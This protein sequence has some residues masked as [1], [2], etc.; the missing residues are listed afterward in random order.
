MDEELK[1]K[2]LM[3]VKRQRFLYGRKSDLDD[4]SLGNSFGLNSGEDDVAGVGDDDSAGATT[5]GGVYDLS[6]I[7]RV[8]NNALNG[9]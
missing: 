6:A 8:R 5:I 9:G 1:I 3:L 4:E 2:A 7:A